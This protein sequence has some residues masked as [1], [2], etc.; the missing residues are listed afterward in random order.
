[1]SRSVTTSHAIPEGSE[2]ALVVFKV[3]P[4]L[5][6]INAESL[7]LAGKPLQDL[8]GL[9]VPQWRRCNDVSNLEPSFSAHRNAMLVVVVAKEF[10]QR[11]GKFD[12]EVGG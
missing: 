12:L 10:D 8:R 5:L 1:M 7:R 4:Y 2:H 9:K 11:L 3:H 6:T